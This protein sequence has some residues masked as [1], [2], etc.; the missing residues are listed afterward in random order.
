MI[1]IPLARRTVVLSRGTWN[2]LIGVTPVGGHR[3]MEVDGCK[4]EWK[5]AQKND[6]KKQTSLRRN[7]TIPIRK[8]RSTGIECFPW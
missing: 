3:S 2:G 8:P 7:R 6:A 5:K 1:V 4:E